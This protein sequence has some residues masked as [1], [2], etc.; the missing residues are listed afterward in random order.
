EKLPIPWVF[1]PALGGIA[2]GIVGMLAPETLGVG[3]ENID[4]LLAGGFSVNEG[5][6]L[7]ILKFVSWSLSLGS[8]TSGGTLAPLF[9]VGGAAGILVGH[10]FHSLSFDPSLPL[11]A[12]VGMA[13]LFAGSSRA[14]FASLL[15]ALETTHQWSALLAV[16]CG[17]AASYLV[18]C[19]YM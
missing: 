10:F 2:V 9:T 1:W 15:F 11:T 14:F 16:L 18:T 3:Y 13:A 4:H 19:L 8:G 17:C 12:L 7:G 5:L 6:H